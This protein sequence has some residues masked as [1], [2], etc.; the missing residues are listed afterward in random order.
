MNSPD[1]IEL[2]WKNRVTGIASTAAGA[3]L[4]VETPDGNYQL[5]CDWVIAADGA[6]SSVRQLLG[7][8]F[9]GVTFEEKFLIADVRVSADYPSDR[10]FWFQPL[11]DPGQ[12]VLIHR[13][14]D[15]VFRIDFQLGWDADPA[16]EREPARVMERVQRVVGA[17]VQ[18]EMEWC[19]VYTFR[20]ARMQRFIDGRVIFAG[21]AAHVV[22]PFGA[23]GGNGGIQDID[24]LCWKLAGVIRGEAPAASLDSYERERVFAADENILHSRRTTAFMSPKGVAEQQFRDAVLDL[25]ADFPFARALINSGRL[26]RPCDYAGLTGIV[27]DGSGVEAACMRG[28]PVWMP[29][30]AR[31][32]HARGGCSSTW[33]PRRSRWCLPPR[34]LRPS[35][36]LRAAE[37]G[38]PGLRVV[39]C[40]PGTDATSAHCA[41]CRAWWRRGMA[42]PWRH[43]PYPPRPTY[44][45]SL[46]ALADRENSV[47]HGVRTTAVT[48]GAR[49]MAELRMEEGFAGRGD[50][51]YERLVGAHQGLSEAESAAL[52]ARLVLLLANHIGDMA[53]LSHALRAARKP[54][55]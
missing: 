28:N 10:R 3:E 55:G 5:H 9:E 41:M 44:P 1:L 6:R 15:E 39:P 31:P 24:N 54:D 35:S 4:R 46:A 32:R 30:C 38:I 27:Q 48:E 23:R 26:S 20:C 18:C 42:A 36:R 37:C 12:S 7:H 19:S 16:R 40:S 17:D 52:N 21:D 25:A 2:R 45:W 22:S 33:V 13:Q 51:F 34:T 29:R 11:F 53:I 47:R 50:E 8:S 43:L 49:E 14:P